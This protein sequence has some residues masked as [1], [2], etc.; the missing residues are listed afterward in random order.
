VVAAGVVGLHGAL[1]AAGAHFL[2]EVGVGDGDGAHQIGLGLVGIAEAGDEGGGTD[3]VG[4]A[5][6]CGGRVLVGCCCGG[7]VVGE[8]ARRTFAVPGLLGHDD[9]VSRGLFLVVCV[10]SPMA[11]SGI[12]R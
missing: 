5:A 11:R 7:R 9:G 8:W 12:I 6:D 3:R 4:R 2:D 1:A 10:A